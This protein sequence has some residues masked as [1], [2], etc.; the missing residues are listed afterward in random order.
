MPVAT[1]PGDRNWGYD[2]AL[3]VGRRTRP[4][5]APTGLAAF[6]DAAHARRARGD[7]RR[8][9]QPPRARADEALEAFGPYLT[10]RYGTPWGKAVNF[11]DADCGGVRE[12]A[13]QNAAMWVRDLHVDGLRVDA[14]HAIYDA[15]RPPRAGGALRPGPRRDAA[16]RRC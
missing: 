15:G 11:D 2:G 6:V 4:T 9:L 14:V 5:A 8:R 13:I 12:W 1:F 10:D 16:S 7:P 3:H